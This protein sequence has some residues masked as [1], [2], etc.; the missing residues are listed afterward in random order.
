MCKIAFSLLLLI[1]LIASSEANVLCNSLSLDKPGSITEQEPNWFHIVDYYSHSTSH[2]W[3]CGPK[4]NTRPDDPYSLGYETTLVSPRLNLERSAKKITLSF[5]QDLDT[6]ND[7]NGGDF[8]RVIIQSDQIQP[9]VI[10]EKNSPYDTNGW[11]Q[12]TID[13][14]QY[15]GQTNF[16][17][18]FVF[19]P[20][21]D[22]NVDR[23]WYI[24]DIRL[25]AQ[26][27]QVD[28]M[29]VVEFDEYL[30]PGWSQ[31]PPYEDT[32]DW[33]QWNINL[34]NV[35]ARYYQPYEYNSI[36]ELTTSTLDATYFTSLYLEYWTLYEVRSPENN[37]H[38]AQVLG[39]ID[40]GA[41]WP[42]EI[43]WY[44][45]NNFT[46]DENIDI[47]SWSAGRSSIKFKFRLDCKIPENVLQWML[48]SI[49]VYGDMNKKYIDEDVERGREGW[50][51][52][53]I[54]YGIQSIS[55][56]E[57]KAIFEQ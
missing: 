27:S 3:Y 25:E 42:Y 16:I 45:F 19:H 10:Y 13:L 15:R 53:P 51:T 7:Y 40:G 1:T 52:V 32:N 48:D 35:A 37:Y 36:D 34:D 41:T 26:L 47:T 46:G 54:E 2:S 21:E 33:H 56:G 39:S 11:K 18:M 57:I 12:E 14:T 29:S 43:K 20:D 49:K 22:T 44:G 4:S 8:C 30:P 50:K 24:D 28:L 23:G 38:H 6:S 9:I 55:I 5:W 31:D 17:I